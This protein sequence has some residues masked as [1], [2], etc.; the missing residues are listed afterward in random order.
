[1]NTRPRPRPSGPA[2]AGA[3]GPGDLTDW[4]L[5]ALG[6]VLAFGGVLTVLPPSDDGVIGV[7]DGEGT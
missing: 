1:M 3:G 6:A 7:S 4:A 5:Y 2:P